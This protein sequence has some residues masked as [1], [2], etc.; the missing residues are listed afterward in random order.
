[1]ASRSAG[2][3]GR[4]GTVDVFQAAA[5]EMFI[6]HMCN[7]AQNAGQQ[8]IAIRSAENPHNF[9]HFCLTC[10]M[11]ESAL[12]RR[13]AHDSQGTLGNRG[14]GGGVAGGKAPSRSSSSS[15]ATA[16]P[17]CSS[18]S[19]S[20]RTG[21]TPTRRGAGTAF[22]GGGGGGGGS[23][24]REKERGRGQDGEED[25]DDQVEED[26]ETTAEAGDVYSSNP[27][28]QMSIATRLH[29]VKKWLPTFAE[30]GQFKRSPSAAA[31]AA[32]ASSTGVESAARESNAA[33][34][35]EFRERFP[36][37]PIVFPRESPE[38]L[39]LAALK[40]SAVTKAMKTNVEKNGGDV[41]QLQRESAMGF[42]PTRHMRVALFTHELCFFEDL[43]AL[44]PFQVSLVVKKEKK[45]F[46]RDVLFVG[47]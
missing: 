33:I 27:R 43:V 40:P 12:V 18:S 39:A 36:H 32:A 28:V 11:S 6:C 9:D 19:S 35:A 21:S 44:K 15:T 2:H 17:A 7:R 30:N 14:I 46:C 16:A 26:I 4:G 20:R 25:G 5:R 42:F 31:A 34:A 29:G 3:G 45:S 37:A 47:K 41:V 24:S 8:R 10:K 23:S 38:T 13:H 1:M 22:G